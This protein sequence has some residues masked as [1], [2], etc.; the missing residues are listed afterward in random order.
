M[1]KNGAPKNL[2]GLQE[3]LRSREAKQERVGQK[4][5][6]YLERRGIIRV[7]RGRVPF[8]VTRRDAKK[9]LK[10][11]TRAFGTPPGLTRLPEL[12]R[13]ARE[14]GLNISTRTIA[15]YGSGEKPVIEGLVGLWYDP[16]HRYAIT[17]EGKKKLLQQATQQRAVERSLKKGKL[18]TLQ[19]AAV[20]LETTE[21]SIRRNPEIKTFMVGEYR[22]VPASEVQKAL[23]EKTQKRELIAATYSTAEAARIFG[24]AI[25]TIHHWVKRGLPAQ[26]LEK[27]VGEKK[28]RIPKEWID[29]HRDEII[30]SKNK[31]RAVRAIRVREF[32]DRVLPIKQQQWRMYNAPKQE[33]EE[34]DYGYKLEKL[35][36]QENNILAEVPEA[37]KVYLERELRKHKPKF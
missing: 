16:R 36:I 15:T 4:F 18:L 28:V 8:S 13:E 9:I 7:Y 21:S 19:Q 23:K 3:F 33:K 20:V 2:I 22:Y 29:R 34:P 11:H 14:K 24:V 1:L 12:G 6:K 30:N 35:I 17:D 5:V 31:A 25:F 27:G 26:V 32:L 37:I 10:W